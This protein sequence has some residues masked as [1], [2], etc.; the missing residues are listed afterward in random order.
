MRLEIIY[1]PRAL[2]G[3]N[4]IADYLAGQSPRLGLRFLRVVEEPC[5]NLAAMPE[6]AG[7][8]ESD[9]PRR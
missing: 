3:M 2:L 1:A 7:R 6:M 5:A 4:E 9:E 8:Y